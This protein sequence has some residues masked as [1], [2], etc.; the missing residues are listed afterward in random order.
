MKKLMFAALV[1]VLSV[2]VT[3]LLIGASAEAKCTYT[4]NS[5]KARWSC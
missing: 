1:A 3:P 4:Q 5:G 2:V